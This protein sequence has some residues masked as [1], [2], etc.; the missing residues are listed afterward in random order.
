MTKS[1][2]GGW[3]VHV[4]GK[5]DGA[6]SLEEALHVIMD[7]MKEYFPSQ[8]VAVILIDQDTKEL[9]IKISR[10]ISY[11]FVKQYH[12]DGPSQIAEQVV[13]E[14]RPMLLNDLAQDSAVYQS[15]KL[16]H[17]FV[18]GVI[19]PV[20]KNQ[21]GVG[22][23]FCDRADDTTFSDPDLLH[24]QV[25]GLLIGSMMEKFELIQASKKLSQLDDATGALQY[26]AFVPAFATE[27]ERASTHEYAVGLALISVEAFRK[28]IET[29]GIDE[30]HGLLEEVAG[31]IK[32]NTRDMD[33]LARFG[34][35]EF[36]L[37]LS[38]L[39][40]EEVQDQLDLIQNAV[41]EQAMGQ[42]DFTICV[43]IGALSL[44]DGKDMKRPLQ[45]I[46][47]ALGKNL[48]AAKGQERAGVVL[49]PLP[50]P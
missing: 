6:L 4:M 33:I 26:K 41:S 36:I 24:L 8:S 29:Y 2:L 39:K 20:I 34:A 12:K 48:V 31:I 40:Q 19:A 35:D 3:L 10:Q 21:R 28:Y 15:L 1:T 7:S 11:T 13:L 47:G 14:Q 49:S 22:Y 37:C 9:R 23:I 50:A 45:D 17:D 16:E 18:S 46:L 5:A 38:G 43:A 27:L 32:S 42:G 30:A 44:S 25:I